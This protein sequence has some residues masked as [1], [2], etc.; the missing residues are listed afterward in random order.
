MKH[1]VQPPLN[2]IRVLYDGLLIKEKIDHIVIDF[3]YRILKTVQNEKEP[4]NESPTVS[5]FLSTENSEVTT[6]TDSFKSNTE[7]TLVLASLVG[8]VWKCTVVERRDLGYS[9]FRLSNL[10]YT[11]FTLL[12]Y[13]NR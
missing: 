6:E 10:T 2:K 12:V 3:I 7:V 11:F 1:T 8:K 5:T 4:L 9:Y 13:E